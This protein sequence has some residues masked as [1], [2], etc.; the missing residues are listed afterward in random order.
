MRVCE[1]GE[2]HNSERHFRHSIQISFD[3]YTIQ[4]SNLSDH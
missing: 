1:K 2:Q 4:Q 3:S